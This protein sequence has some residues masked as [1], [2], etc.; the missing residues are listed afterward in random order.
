MTR[1]LPL[2]AALATLGVT[3]GAPSYKDGWGL[4]NRKGEP[5]VLTSPNSLLPMSFKTKRHLYG[6]QKR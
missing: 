3:A 5:D 1:C 4:L 2:I 6:R